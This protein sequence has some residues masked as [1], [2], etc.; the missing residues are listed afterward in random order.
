[1]HPPVQEETDDGGTRVGLPG[2]D[3]VVDRQLQNAQLLFP[4]RRRVEIDG[5]MPSQPACG[6][7]PLPLDVVHAGAALQLAQVLHT[8]RPLGRFPHLVDGR[9]ARDVT[10]AGHRLERR[11]QR[12]AL[13]RQQ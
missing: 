13:L 1:M 2:A 4:T 11:P 9:S 7:L 8:V 12:N 5:R 10:A 3:A 6:E